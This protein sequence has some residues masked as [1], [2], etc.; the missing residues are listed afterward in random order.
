MTKL[1]VI[2]DGGETVPKTLKKEKITI[3][4]FE[5]LYKTMYYVNYS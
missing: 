2:V 3:E 5:I 4:F 1:K